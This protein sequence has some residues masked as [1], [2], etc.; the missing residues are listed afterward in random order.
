MQY[1]QTNQ[2]Q[3]FS[4]TLTHAIQS[5]HLLVYSNWGKALPTS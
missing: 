2:A 4:E 3:E 5:A 1:I